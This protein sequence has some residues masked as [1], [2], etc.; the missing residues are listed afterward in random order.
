MPL[1]GANQVRGRL[2]QFIAATDKRALQFINAVGAEAGMLSKTKAPLEY[3]TLH[4][5]QRFDVRRSGSLLIGTLSYN[6]KY[7]G[8][9]NN[10]KYAWKPRPPDKKAGPAWNPEAMQ[11]FLEYGFESPEAQQSFKRLLEI[12]KV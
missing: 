2:R 12:F 9:L 8:I 10:G 1:K 6:T 7:A 5:S 4:N 11:G 3:G